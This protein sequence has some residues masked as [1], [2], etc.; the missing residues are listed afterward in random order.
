MKLVRALVVLSALLTSAAVQA[1]PSV[2]TL[3]LEQKIAY[4]Q[5]RFAALYANCG[6]HDEAA[7]LGGSIANWRTE[8]FAGYRGNAQDR[9][10]VEK[11]FDAAVA[12]VGSDSES[13]KNWTQKAEATWSLV[14]QLAQHGTSVLA[15]K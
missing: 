8:T 7:F 10:Q 15:S 5:G 1:A 11:A 14:T 3:D 13:C 2:P 9:A 6:S 4:G 12:A